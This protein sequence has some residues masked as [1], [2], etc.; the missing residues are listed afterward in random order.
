M[1]HFP[2]SWCWE[3]CAQLDYLPCEGMTTALSCMLPPSLDVRLKTEKLVPGARHFSSCKLSLCGS[4]DTAPVSSRTHDAAVSHEGWPHYGTYHHYGFTGRPRCAFTSTL[5]SAR[6]C[7]LQ[8]QQYGPATALTRDA[9]A[10]LAGRTGRALDCTSS[11]G[12]SQPQRPCDYPLPT[13]ES[14]KLPVQ[15][16]GDL[17]ILALWEISA[18]LPNTT[19]ELWKNCMKQ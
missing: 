19:R 13:Q 5:T 14:V 2:E 18:L 4:C 15:G 9:Q 11:R 1:R 7:H 12:P 10:P 6:N 16:E 3:A 17:G 8:Q